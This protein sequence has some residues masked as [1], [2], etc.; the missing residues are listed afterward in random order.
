MIS[1]SALYLTCVSARSCPESKIGLMLTGQVE[2][3]VV[4]LDVAGEAAFLNFGDCSDIDVLVLNPKWAVRAL[5]LLWLAQDN[6]H[7]TSR[8]NLLNHHRLSHELESI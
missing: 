1:P 5:N 4:G 6:P 7:G 3:E 8:T 2:V